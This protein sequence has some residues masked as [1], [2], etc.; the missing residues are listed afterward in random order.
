[1]CARGR[2]LFA[3]QRQARIDAGCASRGNVAG[4]ECD[5]S[6]DRSAT[7][8]YESGARSDGNF[9]RQSHLITR[10]RC[11]EN[12]CLP[13]SVT[14]MARVFRIG[15]IQPSSEKR[16]YM[17]TPSVPAR[18]GRRS[19]QSRHCRAT[20]GSARAD[21]RG[22]T[23]PRCSSHALPLSV[24]ANARPAAVKRRPSRCSASVIATPSHPARCE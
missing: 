9:S 5:R 11:F 2:S 14:R 13:S 8:C 23:I 6:Q 18:W 7:A 1:M 22:T 16:L 4:E 19:V 12:A 21:E 24:T 15:A 20:L 3:A 17:F 10:C